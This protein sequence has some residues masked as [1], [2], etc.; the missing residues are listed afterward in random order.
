[1]E[2]VCKRCGHK[3]K[4]KGN[5]TTHLKRKNACV[6]NLSDVPVEDLLDELITKR[7]PSIIPCRFCDKGFSTL[8]NRW[9]HEQ[10][11][12]QKN[13][14]SI[15][16]LLVEIE[17]LKKRLP[18]ETPKITMNN[19]VNNQININLSTPLREFGFEN[20][21]AIPES[22][23]STCFMFLRFRDLLE[24]L[25]CDP[26]FPENHNVRLKSLKNKT[27]EVYQN[28]K[29][30]VIP[31]QNGLKDLIYKAITIFRDYVNDNKNRIIEEEMDERELETNLKEL[32]KIEEYVSVNKQCLL[33]IVK[34]ITAMLETYRGTMVTQ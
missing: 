33:P 9:R 17:S 21:D 25:H 2:F 3:T 28:K 32:K 27:M 15:H 24:N 13:K 4:T 12:K 5:L 23:I 10:D 7:E 16:D 30:N 19:T 29:W 8:Q 11:C 18:E 20:K 6:A 34:D 14:V 26:N 1:M 31:L 22:L